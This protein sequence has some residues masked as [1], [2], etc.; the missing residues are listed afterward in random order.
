MKTERGP[1]YASLII[2]AL[3]ALA[4]IAA[5]SYGTSDHGRGPADATAAKS[6]TSKR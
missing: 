4:V 6:E 3:V 1:G 2:G 5:I